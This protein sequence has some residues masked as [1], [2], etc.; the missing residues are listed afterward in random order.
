MAVIPLLSFY[1]KR[2]RIDG[3]VLKS[4]MVDTIILVKYGSEQDC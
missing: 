2:L 4:V 1:Q 3:N